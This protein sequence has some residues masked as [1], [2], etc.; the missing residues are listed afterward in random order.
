MNNL[1]FLSNLTST[2]WAAWVQAVG[3]IVAILAAVKMALWQSK[4]QYSDALSLQ[5]S[6]LK[7]SRIENA[8]I[9]MHISKNGV[10]AIDHFISQMSDR[11]SISKISTRETYF[12]FG[13]LDHTVERSMNIPLYN[14]PED[15]VTP[16]MVFSATTRQFKHLVD[17]AI[18]EHKEMVSDDFD[19]L[20]NSL[21]ECRESLYETYT[22]INDFIIREE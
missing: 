18:E 15:L 3:S 6:E 8:K 12:D 16:A 19:E 2:E 9:L 14:L 13:E 5:Q 10:L 17:I 22:K 20:F 1:C 21:K 4:R 11:E 7:R